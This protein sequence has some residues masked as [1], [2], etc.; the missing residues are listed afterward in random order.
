MQTAKP[1]GAETMRECGWQRCSPKCSS[2]T[3]PSVAVA[4]LKPCAG[5]NVAPAYVL[6]RHST[7]RSCTLTASPC[8]CP[9]SFWPTN[10]PSGTPWA[11]T[12]AVWVWAG[13]VEFLC[14]IPLLNGSALAP[15]RIATGCTLTDA[16]YMSGLSELCFIL[17]QSEKS[18]F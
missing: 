2:S 15:C 1:S 3:A 5:V 10:T 8:A 11:L 12:H 6:S 13:A 9:H 18:C 7:C 14:F 17:V 4:L 16:L